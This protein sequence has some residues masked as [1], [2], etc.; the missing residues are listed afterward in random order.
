MIQDG[1]GNG[2]NGNAS[3][4]PPARKL[5]W[6]ELRFLA[7][8]LEAITRGGFPMVPA[9]ASLARDMKRS[10][11]KD[12]VEAIGADLARGESLEQALKRQGNRFPPL[13]LALVRAGEASGDLTGVLALVSAHARS[14]CR[15]TQSIRRA[16]IYPAV[17]VL[18]SFL[19]FGFLLVYVVPPF[20]ETFAAFGLKPPGLTLGFFAVS[21]LLRAYG[22]A[23]GGGLLL[24]ALLAT[25]LV[26]GT[27]APETRRY[28]ADLL[29]LLIPWYGRVYHAILQTRFSRTLRL[30]LAS[31]LPAVESIVL[32]GAATGNAVAERAA[33]AASAQVAA[34]ECLADALHGTGFFS[35]K[36]CWLLG[37]GE[38]RGGVEDALEHIADNLEREVGASEEL[39]G[40]LFAPLVTIV[41]AGLVGLFLIGLYVPIY[42]AGKGLGI[43]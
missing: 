16:L 22:A 30:L 36:F 21:A 15:I 14:M 27:A 7:H 39:F 13:V 31:R 35:H 40:A 33:E 9:L 29:L 25:I 41:V 4:F 26:R 11:L 1:Q 10:R 2:A 43:E 37:A 18:T 19:I 34:G 24:A 38:D 17:L 32:A 23:I 28:W 6:D 42:E 20:Q 8:E 5:S 3:G 12:V